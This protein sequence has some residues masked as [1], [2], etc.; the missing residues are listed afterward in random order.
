MSN[1]ELHKRM[2]FVSEWQAKFATDLE[3]MREVHAADAKLVKDGLI[4]VIDIAGHLARSQMRTDETVNSLTKAQLR[5]DESIRR[6]TDAQATTEASLKILIN[7]VERKIGGNGGSHS[8][9]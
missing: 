7:V 4:G 1:E 9:A 2:E 6:L 8:H 5:T 3:I